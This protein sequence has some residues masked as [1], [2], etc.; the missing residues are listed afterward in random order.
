MKAI[1][2]KELMPKMLV[3]NSYLPSKSCNKYLPKPYVVGE[4]VKVAPWEE[5]KR[6]TLLDDV[7][8][9]TAINKD[10]KWFH[11]HYVVIYRKDEDGKW[12]IKNTMPWEGFD[13]LTF[14][15]HK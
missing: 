12:S 13:L 7:L 15:K 11:E 9:P 1:T 6:S 10:P 4:L 2:K 14:K 8:S 3:V 5:Q